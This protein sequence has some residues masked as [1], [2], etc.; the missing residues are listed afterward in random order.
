MVMV[1]CA[2]VNLLLLIEIYTSIYTIMSS[3]STVQELQYTVDFYS[4]ERVL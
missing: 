4:P 2:V 3:S 1:F